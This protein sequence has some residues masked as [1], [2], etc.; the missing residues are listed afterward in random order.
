M[1]S[2]FAVRSF[3]FQWPAD[4]ATS[5]A[6]EME[7]L[8]LGWYILTTTGSVE[9]L[10]AIAAL[11]WLGSLFSPFFGLLGDRGGHRILLRPCAGAY[12]PVAAVLAALALAGARAPWQVVVAAALAGL[13]RASEMVMRSA[14]VAPTMQ[15]GMLRGALGLSRTA[16]GTPR[17]AGALAGA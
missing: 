6:F 13:L 2:P 9:Q 15:P 5:W 3:R 8:I 4:L 10:V 11:P 1:A 14:L 17:V 12:A 16:S 7:A